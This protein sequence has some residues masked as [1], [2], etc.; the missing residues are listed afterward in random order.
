MPQETPN[1]HKT[2]QTI[3]N[4]LRTTNRDKTYG[5]SFFCFHRAFKRCQQKRHIYVLIMSSELC[6]KRHIYAKLAKWCTTP[7]E[8]R[9][10]IWTFTFWFPYII[11]KILKEDAYRCS[12]C[13][14]R[15]MSKEKP[16][17]HKT[18]QTMFKT[19]RTTN[20]DITYGCSLC[21]FHIRSHFRRWSILCKLL[22][23]RHSNINSKLIFCVNAHSRWF[24]MIHQVWDF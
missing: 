2:C 19:L 11:Q 20:R 16:N 3:F 24:Q 22:V 23:L 14:I 15:I 8:Q 12:N 10:N 13:L 6:Q 7:R 9:Q 5:C 4:I 18:C 1:L 17:L 21:G